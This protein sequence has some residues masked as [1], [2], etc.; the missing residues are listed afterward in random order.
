MSATTFRILGACE[1]NQFELCGWAGALLVLVAYYMVSTE[2]VKAD[3]RPFQLINIVG[4][5]FLVVYT[6]N[7]QAYASMIVNIIWIAIGFHSMF[8]AYLKNTS[9]LQRILFVRTKS[10]V[11]TIAIS[12]TV[13]ISSTS[14]FRLES[15]NYHQKDDLV[16]KMVIRNDE[17]MVTN[18]D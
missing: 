16:S 4:A 7:C 5:I 17:E 15:T 13:I 12:A 9:L 2:K 1:M 3:S 10:K 18:K 14:F 11:L 8:K 6:H